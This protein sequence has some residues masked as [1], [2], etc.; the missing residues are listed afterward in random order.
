MLVLFSSWVDMI[1]AIMVMLILDLMLGRRKHCLTRLN[2]GYL[3]RLRWTM[4]TE[5]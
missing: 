1:I 5:S 2:D 4:A 3:I